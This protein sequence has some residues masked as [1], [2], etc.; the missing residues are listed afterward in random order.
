VYQGS[1][2]RQAS[3]LE[4]GGSVS[5]ADSE[6]ATVIASFTG[7][8]LELLARTG[9]DCGKASVIIDGGTPQEVDLYSATERHR[10]SIFATSSL[11]DATHTALIT[12]IAAKNAAS[13]GYSI[14][15]DALR[16]TGTLSQASAQSA[17]PAHTVSPGSS[18]SS[19]HRVVV[20][21]RGWDILKF[22]R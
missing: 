8:T 11:S 18:G 17:G 1:W 14:N 21:T 4:S 10:V 15:L 12:R 20:L 2:S 19:T 22:A 16:V 6:G 9:P 13:T 3:A 5:R 7:T